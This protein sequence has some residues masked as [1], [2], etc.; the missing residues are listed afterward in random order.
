MTLFWRDK[1]KGS[2]TVE[3]CIALPVFLCFFYLLLFFAK[4]ACINII[5]DN[6][7][8][9]TAQQVAAVSYPLRLVNEYID[10]EMDKGVS[11]DHFFEKG[12]DQEMNQSIDAHLDKVK[13]S[14]IKNIL[15]GKINKS[16]INELLEKIRGATLKK[17]G[18]SNMDQETVKDMQKAVLQSFYDKQEA[19]ITEVCLPIYIELKQSELYYLASEI[20][21]KYSKNSYINLDK[22]NITVFELPQS[23][24]EYKYK[25]ENLW[26]QGSGLKPDIDFN[27]DDVVIQVEYK[28][29]IP[30]PFFGK[31]DIVLRHTAVEKAW[32]YGSNGV[33]AANKEDERIVLED[34][35]GKETTEAYDGIEEIEGK[36]AT[37]N[38]NEEDEDDGEEYVYICENVK[39]VYHTHPFCSYLNKSRFRI[40]LKKAQENGMR[41]HGGCPH[42][43]K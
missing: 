12:L 31:K 19:I 17:I 37:D 36:D 27:Y 41:P 24:A 1:N 16:S 33:Y 3:A 20:H 8:K 13:E 39:K 14:L 28:C 9:E 6:A 26:Y 4:I 18:Q 43:F 29:D 22:L 38:D 32:L 25:K 11:F 5:L 30:L 7:V 21:S 34:Y 15:T 2:L 40:P 23:C 42:R 10:L 35:S